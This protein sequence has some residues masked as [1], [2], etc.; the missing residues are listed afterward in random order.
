MLKQNFKAQERQSWSGFFSL[1]H[2]EP[3]GRALCTFALRFQFLAVVLAASTS[4][5]AVLT[6]MIEG[7][8]VNSELE[9]DLASD[10]GW[11]NQF[12][13]AFPALIYIAG[14][15]FG[16]F[17]R[18]LNSL[19]D[20]GVLR[21]SDEEWEK[22]RVFAQSKLS[23]TFVL[24]S[25]Y[26][27]GLAAAAVTST[28]TFTEGAWFSTG[29]YWSGWLIPL[30]AFFL[31][32]FMTYLTLRLYAAYRVLDLLFSFGVNIQPLHADGSGGLGSLRRLSESLYFGLLMF[33]FVVALGVVSNTLVY[34]QELFSLFNF[35]MYFG[36]AAL[37]AVAF[38]LPTYALSAHMREAKTK[39]LETIA[40]RMAAMDKQ[41]EQGKESD[42][43]DLNALRTLRRSAR[44]MQ[45]WPFDLMSLL[46]FAAVVISP[47]PAIAVALQFIASQVN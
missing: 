27:C 44:S 19:V 47:L 29:Q 42:E 15:Y 5:T 10:I 17:P 40:Q 20:D 41:S 9:L 4:L 6:T 46:R 13:L 12:A 3:L 31:Y 25:P 21:A 30:H 1:V 24:L 14:A 36:Y 39:L 32:F 16:E 43:A 2:G 38:F 26:L 35:L 8:L 34:G 7:T 28:V 23:Q 45:V 33:G 37:T 18:T 22:V 11:W